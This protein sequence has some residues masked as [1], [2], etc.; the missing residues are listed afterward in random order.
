M[1]KGF[2]SVCLFLGLAAAAPAATNNI[3]AALV[4]DSDHDGATDWE[5]WQAD[6]NPDDPSNV[7]EVTSCRL[8]NGKVV[9]T[10]SGVASSA[11]EVVTAPTPAG[12]STNAGAAVIVVPGG[13]TGPWY[14]VAASV[15]NQVVSTGAFFRVELRPEPGFEKA[16]FDMATFE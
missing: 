5:E 4:T 3:D 11:Y 9:V 7:F 6:T 12:F 1:R 8:Q 14:Q 2:L 10:W 16:V 15:T 13:G